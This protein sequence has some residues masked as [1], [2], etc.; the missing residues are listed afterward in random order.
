M[1]EVILKKFVNLAF[2]KYTELQLSARKKSERKVKEEGKKALANAKKSVHIFSQ[3]VSDFKKTLQTTTDENAT[4]SNA[5]FDK[6]LGKN[7]LL[8]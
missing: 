2:D 3:H 5:N 4:P 8:R 1:T 7:G 6:I